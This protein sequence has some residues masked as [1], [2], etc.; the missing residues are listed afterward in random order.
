[1]HVH[2]V[3]MRRVVTL[4]RTPCRTVADLAHSAREKLQ[5]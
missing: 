3:G 2:V 1:M 5:H 4:E